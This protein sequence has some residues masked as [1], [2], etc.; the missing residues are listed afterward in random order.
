MNFMHFRIYIV[1]EMVSFFRN[2]L[3]LMQQLN[4]L[5]DPDALLVGLQ[6]SELSFFLPPQNLIWTFGK[7]LGIE[8]VR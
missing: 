1:A 6:A 2:F 4:L 7:D 5:L 3:L 8:D